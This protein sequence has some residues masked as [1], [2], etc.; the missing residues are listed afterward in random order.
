MPAGKYTSTISQADADKKAD[1]DILANGQTEANKNL[2][3][4]PVTTTP[5]VTIT[6]KGYLDITSNVAADY[7]ITNYYN[8]ITPYAKG[9]L[10]AGV[11]RI[12]ISKVTADTVYVW[13][14]GK[15]GQKITK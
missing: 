14:N 11:N 2:V 1:D 3:C 15:R 8:N 5:T 4:T 12:D 7:I 13:I 10:T 6:F 9:Q